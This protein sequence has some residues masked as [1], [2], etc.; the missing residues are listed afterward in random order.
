M[1]TSD[2]YLSAASMPDYYANAQLVDQTAPTTELYN[3][4]TATRSYDPRFLPRYVDTVY[5]GSVTRSASSKYDSAA[6]KVSRAIAANIPSDLGCDYSLRFLVQRSNAFLWAH[7]IHYSTAY[8][9]G[10]LDPYTN[11]RYADN[12]WDPDSEGSGTDPLTPLPNQGNCYCEEAMY[13]VPKITY[14]YKD[15]DGNTQ[16]ATQL[17]NPRTGAGGDRAVGA[18]VNNNCLARYK[19]IDRTAEWAKRTEG[20]KDGGGVPWLGDFCGYVEETHVSDCVAECVTTGRAT[21][22]DGLK[23]PFYDDVKP[24]E[25]VICPEG[26]PP[27]KT[28][29]NMPTSVTYKMCY[30]VRDATINCIRSEATLGWYS[31][32]PWCTWYS[33]GPIREIYSMGGVKRKTGLNADGTPETVE[34]CIPYTVKLGYDDHGC[35]HVVSQGFSGPTR[36]RNGGS[37]EMPE[38]VEMEFDLVPESELPSGWLDD[39]DDEDSES[40]IDLSDELYPSVSASSL[41][42]FRDSKG[43]QT[44]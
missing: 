14:Q 30:R 42:R 11:P 3:R 10:D 27:Y 32:F 40:S 7:I 33:F 9:R 23:G 19:S 22:F 34:V 29:R 37:A 13:V 44:P 38:G 20:L 31:G 35:P 43:R 26:R 24:V 36:G 18:K 12:P 39:D 8:E 1:A 41:Q 2:P 4:L 5:D 25:M 21:A 6:P 15:E 16:T 17:V 28:T